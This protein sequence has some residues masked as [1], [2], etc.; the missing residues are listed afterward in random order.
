[1]PFALLFGL[2]LSPKSGPFSVLCRES[3]ELNDEAEDSLPF[4]VDLE[5][6]EEYQDYFIEILSGHEIV[7]RDSCTGCTMQ[8]EES[9]DVTG[10][11]ACFVWLRQEATSQKQNG[12]PQPLSAV[13]LLPTI[14]H[15]VNIEI[16]TIGV[17]P[18]RTF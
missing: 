5:W 1:M 18:A 9:K 6:K 3:E 15:V 2:I 10:H 8:L 14:Q 12:C 13:V 16:R 11:F 4:S 7:K 17:Y